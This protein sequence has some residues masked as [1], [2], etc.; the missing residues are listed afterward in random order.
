LPDRNVRRILGAL[1]WGPRGIR[2]TATRVLEP[3]DVELFLFG[4]LA[5]GEGRAASEIDLAL[6]P[7]REFPLTVLARLEEEFDES[8]VPVAVD[9]VDLRS[10]GDS[11]RAKVRAEGIRWIAS[12]SA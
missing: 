9:L 7:K 5:R 1:A 11:L 4:S 12:K 3:Y 6:E 8:N 2:A 10:A